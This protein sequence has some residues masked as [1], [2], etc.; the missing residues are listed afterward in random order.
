MTTEPTAL[1]TN[2]AFNEAMNSGMLTFLIKAYKFPPD[3]LADLIIKHDN[4]DKRN[5]VTF[6]MLLGF[7]AT[8]FENVS[9][10]DLATKAD[11]L[12]K[13]GLFERF[14]AKAVMLTFE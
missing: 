13:S 1:E 12:A 3:M 6:M 8:T 4:L 10:D 2:D 7:Y 11:E 9:L 5:E 14:L